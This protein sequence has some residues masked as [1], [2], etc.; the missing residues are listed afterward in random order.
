MV[1]P[2]AKVALVRVDHSKIARGTGT[3]PDRQVN[4]RI[5]PTRFARCARQRLMRVL[6]GVIKC[7][8]YVTAVG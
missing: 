3:L 1:Y 4:T 7:E 6:L 8:A 2:S 5:K